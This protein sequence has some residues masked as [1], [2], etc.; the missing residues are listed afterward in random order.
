M[1]ILLAALGTAGAHGQEIAPAYKLDTLV[2]PSVFHGIQGMK[3]GPDGA[4]Y[5]ADIY[6]F[7]IWRVDRQT[8]AAEPFVGFPYGMADDL[9][10]SPSGLLA[11]TSPGRVFG[12]K[13]GGPVYLIADHLPG[14]NGIGFTRSG[15]LFVTQISPRTNTLVELDPSGQR[16]PHV[17]LD[18]TG[19][20]NGF[21][22]DADDV[23]W[24]P[25]GWL[26]GGYGNIVRIDL[27]TLA[28]SIVA[29]GFTTPTGVD[30]GPDG[31]LY[32]VDFLD[33]AVIRVDPHTGRKAQLTQLDPWLDN[34]TVSAD[35]KI[36]VSDTPDDTIWEIDA[37][38]AAIRALHKG[39]LA[40]P[41]GLAIAPGPDGDQ[42]YVADTFT[43]KS[44]DP[45]TGAV[46]DW[47]HRLGQPMLA[48]SS[49]RFS[50]GSLVA[51]SVFGSLEVIDPATHKL[52]RTESGLASPEDAVMLNNGD[53]IVAEYAKGRLTRIRP[54]GTRSVLAD[55]LA[56]PVGVAP[57]GEGGLYVSEATGGDIVRV[58]AVSGQKTTV[59]KGLRQPEGLDVGPD[60][61]LYGV[62]G[63]GGRVLRVDPATGRVAILAAGLP[64]GIEPPAEYAKIAAEEPTIMLPPSPVWVHNGIAVSRS[65][66]I[67]VS[68]DKTSALLS[69][70]P[71]AGRQ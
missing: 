27:K 8:G 35:D 40:L 34:L 3:I 11:W 17:L 50:R 48:A 19:G 58:D 44:V 65:G 7:T 55:G 31:F 51:T 70:T 67:Y 54:D 4:L 42:I 26:A 1:A 13:P 28:L 30:I 45:K 9:A 23:L 12:R 62:E 39:R 59:V 16:R 49:L 24:G 15:R 63:A 33:G 20:I 14:V 38:T 53:L 66:V 68:A 18:H 52:T 46:V 71:V 21:R 56:G 25:Q 5:V 69:L 32:A 10:F 43:Y 60:G 41:G 29:S 57:D 64:I 61:L 47:G 2:A 22:I 6:G 37:K 36:Y